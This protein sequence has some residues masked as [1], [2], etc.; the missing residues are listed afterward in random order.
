MSRRI[1]SVDR[2]AEV[3]GPPR[4]RPGD[5]WRAGGLSA[6]TSIAASLGLLVVARAAGADLVVQPQGQAAMEVGP[7][8]I[9]VVIVSAVLVGSLLLV[10]ARRSAP[11]SW[12]RLAWAGF[13]LGLVTVV[14]P[15]TVQA[16]TGTA[17]ALASMHVV[18]GTAW[19]GF[20]RRAAGSVS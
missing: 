12:H 15:F 18:T 17:L 20:V 3:T 16:E 4:R 11:R 2:A 9:V 1:E 14:A 13:A 8:M 19:L 6:L 7:L 10:L 5:A